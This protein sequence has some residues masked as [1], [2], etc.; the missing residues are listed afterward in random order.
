VQT[1]VKQNVSHPAQEIIMKLAKKIIAVTVISTAAFGVSGKASAHSGAAIAA[2]AVGGL[3]VGSALSAHAAPAP[4][5]Q[6]APVVYAPQPVYYTAPVYYR[7]AP[8]VHYRHHP[9]HYSGYYH[10]DHGYHR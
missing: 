8:S 2:I 9:R 6:P 7:G 4:V 1:K 10:R 5:V 3:I